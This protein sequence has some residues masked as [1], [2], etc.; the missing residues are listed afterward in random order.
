[1]K[2]TILIFFVILTSL[3]AQTHTWELDIS[4]ATVQFRVQHMLIA[5]VTGK[6][7]TFSGS[8]KL[9]DE[10]FTNA[11]ISGRVDVNSIDTDNERRDNHLKSKDFFQTDQYPEMFFKSKTVEQ[12]DNDTYAITGDLTIKDVTKTVT[13]EAQHGGTI[14]IRGARRMGWH[15]TATINRFDF[16]LNWNK[17]IETG[18][19][20]VDEMVTIDIFAE[21]I[22]QK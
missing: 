20:V 18:G 9:S 11:Q 21:F 3:F 13:F 7:N 15:A 12:I 8:V 16:G 5:Q 6:F 1:M 10:D 22:E 14:T 19:L 2:K 17:T 4:H